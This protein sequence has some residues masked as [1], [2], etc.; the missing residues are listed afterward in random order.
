MLTVGLVTMIAGGLRALR[1]YDLK[2]LLAHGTVSQLGFLVVLFG[3]GT[4]AATQAGI[5]LL[6][7]HALFKAMAFMVVGIVDHQAGTRDIRLLAPLLHG[8]AATKVVAAVSA[9]SMAG[10]PLLLGFVAKESAY[11]AFTDGPFSG[12]GLVLAGIVIGSTLTVA[13]QPRASCRRF[14]R[15][16]DRAG[17]A[18]TIAARHRC[19]GSSRLPSSSV[20]S[21]SSPGSCR[22]RSIVSSERRRRALD[23]GQSIRRTSRSGTGSTPPSC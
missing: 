20:P 14:R 19:D 5:V 2:L 13:L 7:A 9:A 11:A 18:A 17:V 16:V 8:W 12:S 6:I 23:P 10:V 21:R 15:T 4:T 22:R 1:Q 3:A